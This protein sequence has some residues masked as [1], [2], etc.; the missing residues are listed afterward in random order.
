MAA[1]AYLAGSQTLVRHRHSFGTE[2]SDPVSFPAQAAA[3]FDDVEGALGVAEAAG[4]HDG[5]PFSTVGG[6]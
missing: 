3:V 6:S 4:G 1:N 5:R 2:G